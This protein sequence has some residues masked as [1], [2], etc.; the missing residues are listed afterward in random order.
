MRR[1]RASCIATATARRRSS[2]SAR[3]RAS[4]RAC[5]RRTSSRI[6]I[7]I[8]SQPSGRWR[9]WRR[10]RG[11]RGPPR[12]AGSPWRVSAWCAPPRRRP[13][14]R[15]AEPAIATRFAW[16]ADRGCACRAGE[17][18]R[19]LRVGISPALGWGPLYEPHR[20]PAGAEVGRRLPLAPGS[21]RL[22]L[23]ARDL[24]G[25]APSLLVVPDRPGAVPRKTSFVPAASGWDTAFVVRPGE[26]AVTL[27]LEGGG[28]LLVNELVLTLQPSRPGPV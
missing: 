1:S 8:G 5:C 17:S 9:C 21:Y 4:G 12:R 24:A 15:T 14:C 2:A 13:C 11:V 18:A 26:R 20:H 25:A 3:A 23:V 7:V 22:T 28:P 27:L 19:S 16:W 6:R 10:Y